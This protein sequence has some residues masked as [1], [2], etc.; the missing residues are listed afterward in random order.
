MHEC[1]EAAKRLLAELGQLPSL[2]QA[3]IGFLSFLVK[4]SRAPQ[5][6]AVPRRSFVFAFQEAEERGD[7]KGAAPQLPTPGGS[8]PTA[9]PG[10]CSGFGASSNVLQHP[11]GF[12][13]PPA[14][15]VL[16]LF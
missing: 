12:L 3:G 10:L 7:T 8:S 6:L 11:P 4:P 5:L 14:A 15:L 13:C 2:P 9:L 16:L 1:V